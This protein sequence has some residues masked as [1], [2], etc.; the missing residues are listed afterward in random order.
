MTEVKY[1]L[2]KMKDPFKP[3]TLNVLIDLKT[4]KGIVY[5]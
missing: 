3:N 2:I 4:K 5:V 1:M